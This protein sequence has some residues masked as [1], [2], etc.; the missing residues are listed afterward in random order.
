MQLIMGEVLVVNLLALFSPFIVIVLPLMFLVSAVAVLFESIP[1]LSKGVGNVFY[2]IIWL[3][4]V[5]ILSDSFDLFGSNLIISSM[6]AAGRVV[7]PG[8]H[9]IGFI[10]GYSWGFPEGRTL[11][12]F[13]WSGTQWTF[14]I[15]QTRLLLV[16]M[17]V[18]IALIA[19]LSFNRFD[20]SSESNGPNGSSSKVINMEIQAVQV[21]P[22]NEIK[23]LSFGK[24]ALRF[25]IVSMLVAECRLMLWEFP[26]IGG[27]GLL[28]AATFI[29]A[30]LVVPADIARGLL[31][32]FAWLI[33]VLYWSRLG[34]REIRH[35]TGQ[36]VFSSARVLMRQFWAMWLTGVIV[37]L[38]FGGG[39]IL[40]MGIKGDIAVVAALVVGA[41][42]I[43]SLSLFLGVWTGSCK[44][45]EFLYTLFWY[46]GPMNGVIPLDFMGVVPA[47]VES[48]VWLWYYGATV[49]L[50]ALAFMGRKKQLQKN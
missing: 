25:D 43:P 46:I 1:L 41:I 14:E 24:E 40:N 13:T 20:P 26:S 27:L 28:G 44:V 21:V 37:S 16:G 30:G 11:S 4:G 42:F 49:V 29:F 48:G 38:A 10:L 18:L 22:I 2:V 3:V 12:T 23:L 33:P 8:M 50:I 17:S 6:E 39:V 7:F 32:P 35:G 19:S 36:L 5:P 31:L 9:E 47:S 15:L 34:V 45:F